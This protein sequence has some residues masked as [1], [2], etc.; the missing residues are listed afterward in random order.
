V[1]LSLDQEKELWLA[2][3]KSEV[4]EGGS[5]WLE[6]ITTEPNGPIIIC[7]A[8][9]AVG[10]SGS[11]ES[12]VLTLE[13]NESVQILHSGNLGRG[14]RI[15]LEHPDTVILTEA[16]V[17][18][19]R[20]SVE[21]GQLVEEK[22]KRDEMGPADAVPAYFSLQGNIIVTIEKP[23]INIKVGQ[24]VSFISADERTKKTGIKT[25][26]I[27]TMSFLFVICLQN[28]I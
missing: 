21:N 13:S 23:V 25:I 26:P 19:T 5:P 4:L 2:I 24:T 1:H 27:K 7:A 6:L 9:Y 16:E 10:A 12:Y 17:G 15:E 18:R 3:W 22:V 11:C 28:L 20:Y 8:A 14:G